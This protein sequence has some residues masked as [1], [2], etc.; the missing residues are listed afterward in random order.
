MLNF[1]IYLVTK[2]DQ[3]FN[4]KSNKL[5]YIYINFSNTHK[6]G[7]LLSLLTINNS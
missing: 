3:I 5:T 6:F 1:F 7:F 2:G 4:E